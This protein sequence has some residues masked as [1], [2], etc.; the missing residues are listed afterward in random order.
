MV[1]VVLRMLQAGSALLKRSGLDKAVLAEV[2]KNAKKD[3]AVPP[4]MMSKAELLKACELVVAAG[5]REL[6]CFLNGA[7]LCCYLGRS[8]PAAVQQ[9]T[10]LAS[11]TDV[12]GSGDDG[13][14]AGGGGGGAAG[15]VGVKSARR[16][17]ATAGHAR[18]AVAV[19]SDA[20]DPMDFFKKIQKMGTT[21]LG[22]SS[23]M[24]PRRPPQVV[25]SRPRDDS[26]VDHSRNSVESDGSDRDSPLPSL[27]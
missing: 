26:Q 18:R 14:A 27:P 23:R 9:L 21:D 12:G 25:D 8:S 2:W 4:T 5:G 19:T 24:T 1:V 17:Q 6:G 7:P 20:I 15:G 10:T 11:A 16:G 13:S 22:S 3:S